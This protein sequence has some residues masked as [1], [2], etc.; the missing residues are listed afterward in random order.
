MVKKK[1]TPISVSQEENIQAQQLL[2]RYPHIATTLRTSTEQKEVEIA[3]AEVESLPEGAQIALV[4]GLAGE[5]QTDSAD[6]LLALNEFG[7]LKNVRKEA[8]RALIRLKGAKISP[9]WQPPQESSPTMVLTPVSTNPPRFWKGVVTDSRAEGEVQLLLAWQQ[10]EDYK[11]VRILSF[12]LEFWRDGVKD[13]FTQI[14]SRRSFE[15]L[16]A[17]MSRS[18]MDV[19]LKDCDAIEGRRLLQ[20]ALAVNTRH[21]TRPHRE[22]QLHLS[23]INQLLPES[24][25]ESQVA[26]PEEELDLHDLDPIDVVSTFV[27]FWIDGDY[28]V[29]Y[30][31]LAEQSPLREGFTKEEW[32]ER[33]SAWAEKF[34][35]GN[36]ETTIL[37]EIEPQKPKIWQPFSRGSAQA[38]EQK[39]ILAGWSL[40]MEGTPA[41]DPLPEW[42]LATA[43]YEETRRHWFWARYTL[44]Q[45]DGEW[46]IQNMIDEGVRTQRLSEEELRQ[47]IRENDQRLETFAQEHQPDELADLDD[48]E[49]LSSFVGAVNWITESTYCV[50]ALLKKQPLE[51]S[52]YQEA[53]ARMLTLGQHERSLVYLLPLVQRFS[54]ERGR[55]FRLL[56][57]TYQELSNRFF[58]QGDDERAEHFL[59]LAEQALHDSLA[60]EDHI[61]AHFSLAELL[62]EEGER[63]DEAEEQLARARQLGTG[64]DDEAHVELHLAEIAEA[65]EQYRQALSH[66]QRITE[67]KPDSASAWAD[68]AEAHLNLDNIEEV[69]TSY[70]RAIGLDPENE[71]YYSSLA[72]MY[73]QNNQAERA[74][75]V[76]EQGIRA[77]PHAADLYAKQAILF[78]EKDDY[79]QA[80]TLLAK[81]EELDPESELVLNALEILSVQKASHVQAFHQPPR[82]SGKKKKGRRHH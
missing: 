48:D 32:G 52:L 28:D 21:G 18:L 70:H 7:T 67:I 5:H 77:N 68:L 15:N 6:V 36:L 43:V 58:D 22:Y 49:M 76:L 1:H 78:L 39:E 19:P 20:E 80:E 29:A 50:D 14:E 72:L 73:K 24:L 40:E 59:K 9:R 53:A 4:K 60:A 26:G 2:E 66:Y 34:E 8:K 41:S 30:S 13:F 62:I 81:A 82:F 23:L 46:R 25:A 55:I 56:A 51:R 35:P 61:E 47:Q 64:P 33:R 3:L 69:A 75:A 44:V 27:E 45:E 74:L 65:R 37:R 10:G 54:E 38:A 63:L 16:L 31:L 42:P 57:H 71:D 12:L 17:R 79:K 11:E